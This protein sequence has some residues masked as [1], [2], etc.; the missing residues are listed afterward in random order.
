LSP[1]AAFYMRLLRQLEKVDHPADAVNPDEPEFHL[2]AKPRGIFNADYFAALDKSCESGKSAVV[3][4]HINKN[5]TF[6]F[7]NSTDVAEA[8]EFAAVLKEVRRILGQL[9][10]QILNG[11]V[12]VRP[13]RLGTLT[14]CSSCHYRSVCRFDASINRYRNIQGEKRDDLLRKLAEEA[15][16]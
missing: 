14:P 3:A 16:P 12:G 13:Y 15:Q 5:G 10:E 4:A 9:A 6:G 11:E 2:A 8:G 7:R 1:A